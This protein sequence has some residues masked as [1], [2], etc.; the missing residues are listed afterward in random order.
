MRWAVF[1]FIFLTEL[2]LKEKEDLTKTKATQ[3]REVE[4]GGIAQTS[5]MVCNTVKDLSIPCLAKVSVKILV[6]TSDA[7]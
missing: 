5:N 7:Q 1:L 6:E 3:K 2:I 4:E